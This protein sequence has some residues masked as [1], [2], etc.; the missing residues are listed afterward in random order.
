[1]PWLLRL[2]PERPADPQAGDAWYLPALV[3][4]PHA[5]YYRQHLLSPEYLRDWDGVRPPIA[6]MCPDG[7]PWV[8][9]ERYGR[10]DASGQRVKAGWT[11]TGKPPCLTV[12]PSINVVG[13]YHGWLI[14][15]LLTDDIEGRVF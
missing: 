5:D 10:L 12:T 3:T 7:T 11:V 1:M 2:Y 9:D 6:V 13:R 4:G 15:G 14:E 8:V